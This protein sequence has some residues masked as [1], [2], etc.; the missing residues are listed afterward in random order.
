MTPEFSPVLQVMAGRK[1]NYN[2][3]VFFCASEVSNQIKSVS[4]GTP[5]FENWP[6]LCMCLH[7]SSFLPSVF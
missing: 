4:V 7:N 6:V 2:V 5:F 3:Q 1:A